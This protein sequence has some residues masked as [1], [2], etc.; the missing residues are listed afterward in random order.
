MKQ[1]KII[2]K[3]LE[4]SVSSGPAHEVMGKVVHGVNINAGIMVLDTFVRVEFWTPG[5]SSSLYQSIREAS[6]SP[7]S[8]Y[9]LTIINGKAK[10]KR[11]LPSTPAPDHLP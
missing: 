4:L 6:V 3:I 10:I 9:M 5:I 8:D 7:E 2:G 1:I 11:L